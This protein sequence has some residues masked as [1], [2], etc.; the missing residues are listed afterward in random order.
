MHYNIIIIVYN[1]IQLGTIVVVNP[2]KKN[3][4]KEDWIEKT[5]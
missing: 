1:C 4:E 5:C 3:F 2:V